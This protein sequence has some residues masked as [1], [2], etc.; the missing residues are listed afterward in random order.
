MTFGRI[1]TLAFIILVGLN[2][3]FFGSEMNIPLAVILPISGLF[4]AVLAYLAVR[5]L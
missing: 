4:G 3:G 5:H 2:L 1:I